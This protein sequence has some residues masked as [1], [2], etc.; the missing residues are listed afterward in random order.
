MRFLEEGQERNKERSASAYCQE[1]GS[2]PLAVHIGTSR[3][4]EGKLHYQLAS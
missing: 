1:S 3:G 2:F 4:N